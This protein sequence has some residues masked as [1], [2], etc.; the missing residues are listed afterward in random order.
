MASLAGEL[1]M[2]PVIPPFRYA[3]V[4][5]GVHRGAHPSLKNMRY[6]RRLK[7]RTIVSLIPDTKNPSSDLVEF[8]L[9][10]GITHRCHQVLKYDD[11]FSHTPELV[12]NVLSQ[13]IDPR[14][15][16]VF[17]HCLDGRQN[18]GIVVMCLRKLQNWSLKAILEEFMRYAKSNE[19]TLEEQHFV[20]AFNTAVTVPT[21]VPRWLSSRVR[22]PTIQ[23]QLQ[24]NH[25][26]PLDVERL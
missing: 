6:M 23:N 26:Q 4:E 24:H 19:S 9:Q 7:L 12:A 25:Q 22:Y 3:T 18:T 14:N 13:L 11:G 20:Q 10:E 15:H 17:L 21:T 2:L 1:Q 8:C 5:D 16:P